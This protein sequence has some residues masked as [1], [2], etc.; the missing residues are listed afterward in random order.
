MKFSRKLTYAK[1]G[2]QHKSTKQPR[3]FE[4]IFSQLDM[5]RKS[6]LKQEQQAAKGSSKALSATAAGHAPKV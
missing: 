5:L 1:E 4:G 2:R 3:K 6:D